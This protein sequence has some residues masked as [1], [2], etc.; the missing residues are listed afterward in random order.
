ML[1]NSPPST[2]TLTL[3]TLVTIPTR[4]SKSGS[5]AS[6]RVGVPTVVP[7]RTRF[8]STLL[9]LGG[10]SRCRCLC[11]G[12]FIGDGVCSA[13]RC[14]RRTRVRPRIPLHLSLITI[15]SSSRRRSQSP[16]NRGKV[17]DTIAPACLF[18]VSTAAIASIPSNRV[19]PYGME[20][21]SSN[22]NNSSKSIQ[23]DTGQILLKIISSRITCNNNITILMTPA[24]TPMPLINHTTPSTPKPPIIRTI[25]FNSR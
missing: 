21:A 22:F 8:N 18:V 7:R 3:P 12:R 14:P 2:P 6:V 4:H 5:I 11:Q 23:M 13:I 25:N 9:V 19:H 10:R 24:S 16:S 15:T 1:F 17:T 20:E